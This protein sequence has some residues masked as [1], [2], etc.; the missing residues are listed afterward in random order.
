M[1]NIKISLN[2]QVPDKFISDPNHRIKI[3]MKPIV[4]LRKQAKKH[5]SCTTLLT[6]RI[7]KS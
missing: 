7:K 4:A 6:K 3:T 1:T 5:T 2:I